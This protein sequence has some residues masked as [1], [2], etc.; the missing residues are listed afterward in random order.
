MLNGKD[1]Q[2]NFSFFTLLFSGI[3]VQFSGRLFVAELLFFVVFLSMVIR[4]SLQH[5][6]LHS[7]LVI[8]INLLILA[9]LGQ[10]ISDVY[11]NSENQ[12][13]IKGSLLIFFTIVNLIV[14]AKIVDKKLNRYLVVVVLYSISSMTSYV[15]QPQI[16]E[17]ASPWK[18]GFG[19]PITAIFFAAL[20]YKRQ[21]KPQ[22]ILALSL[23]LAVVDFIFGARNLALVTIFTG[24]KSFI[25][26][27]GQLEYLSKGGSENFDKKV[28]SKT[29]QS[30]L[31][32]FVLVVIVGSLVFFGYKSA[33]TN[34]LLGSEA[35]L[36]F[37]QQ[38]STNTNLLFTSRSEVFSQ[39]IA[40]RSSPLVGHGSYAPLTAEIR[41]K[42]L[43]W[44]IE[45]R[46][47][48]NLIQLE[49]GTRYVIPVHSGI[50]GFW[51]WFGILSVPFFIYTFKLAFAVVR[52]KRSS[53]IIYYFA[54]LI[55]WD[56]LFSPF[57][58]YARMQ[59]PITL[60][61]M[62]LFSEMGKGMPNEK[63]SNR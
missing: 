18:F 41:E 11:R 47:Q 24:V 51:V 37:N 53:P 17:D 39:F 34:G 57:G 7:K 52:T 49:S 35:E 56:I 45:N 22:T 59:Y 15:I 46:L 42:L 1:G 38:T 5:H 31:G 4:G 14:I 30:T 44:L 58:M 13:F 29:R 27:K 26:R 10:I 61:G 33:V 54:I 50:F 25:S 3:Y 55:C 8:A 9:L 12:Y 40:I 48:T 36:K 28:Q 60:I 16:F 62:L 43:P 6:L 21:L 2:S 20:T 32:L 63:R 19:Y 23:L